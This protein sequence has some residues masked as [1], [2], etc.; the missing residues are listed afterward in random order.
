MGTKQKGHHPTWLIPYWLPPRK[1]SLQLP[2]FTTR[3][4]NQH[5]ILKKIEPLEETAHRMQEQSKRHQRKVP[6]LNPLHTHQ[7]TRGTSTRSWLWMSKSKTIKK[8]EQSKRKLP[9]ERKKKKSP[10]KCG[11]SS[12]NILATIAG[13]VFKKPCIFVT[14]LTCSDSIFQ[15]GKKGKQKK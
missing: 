6:K 1:D 15:K 7:A 3:G 8:E 13:A 10:G 4:L 12:S 9:T 2:M 14:G 5:P 11:K